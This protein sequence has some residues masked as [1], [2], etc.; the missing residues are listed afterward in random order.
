[1]W[2][3]LR[4]Q[5]ALERRQLHRLL[6]IYRAL[7]ERCATSTPDHIEISALAAMLHSFYNF[8][9]GLNRPQQAFTNR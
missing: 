1:V 6:E 9:A 2:D 8:L 3:E 5:V 4:E 7:L